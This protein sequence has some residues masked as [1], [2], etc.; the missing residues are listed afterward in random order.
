MVRWMVGFDGTKEAKNAVRTT[1]NMMN[2]ESDDLILFTVIENVISSWSFPYASAYPYL[3][4]TQRSL[5]KD[6][7]KKSSEM[8]KYCI[9]LQ[10]KIC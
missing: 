6:L 1:M 9:N 2:K 7:K 5:E 4:E 8:L 3:L 10:V